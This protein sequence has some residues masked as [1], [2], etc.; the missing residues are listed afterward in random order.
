[1]IKY[2]RPVNF[3]PDS[4]T[5]YRWDIN[6]IQPLPDYMKVCFVLL[7]NFVHQQVYRTLR[8]QNLN[9]LPHLKKVV[10]NQALLSSISSSINTPHNN[11][12]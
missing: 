10:I 4:A 9:V 6:S 7:Y 11:T 8:E 5:D 2:L 1:M 12:D 3:D